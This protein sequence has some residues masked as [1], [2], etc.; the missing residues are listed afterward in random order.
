MELIFFLSKTNQDGDER[1]QRM[2]DD[3]G[4]SGGEENKWQR[5]MIMKWMMVCADAA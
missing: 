2:D 5:K 4:D 1:Q 3:D